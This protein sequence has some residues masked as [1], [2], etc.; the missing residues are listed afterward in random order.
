MAKNKPLWNKLKPHLKHKSYVKM[1]YYGYPN[2]I[3]NI[4]IECEKCNEVIVDVD[5]SD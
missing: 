1:V 5:N 4:A 3:A 2:D